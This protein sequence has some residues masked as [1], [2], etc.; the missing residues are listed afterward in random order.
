MVCENASTS[1]SLYVG[2]GGISDSDDND[3]R[4][5]RWGWYKF[6]RHN[7]TFLFTND[8]VNCLLLMLPL[9]LL[10]QWH[11]AR[12]DIFIIIHT[13]LWEN[14]ERTACAK[15]SFRVVF[16]M[17]GGA[18]CGRPL[19][20]AHRFRVC[21]HFWHRLPRTYFYLI[22]IFTARPAAL[23][24]PVQSISTFWY[25]F[26]IHVNINSI[27]AHEW[28]VVF[29]HAVLCTHTHTHAASINLVCKCFCDGYAI[30]MLPDSKIS[31]LNILVHL[32]SF[33]RCQA[34]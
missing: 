5:V 22:P 15:V 9:L 34:S 23:R 20:F 11:K 16:H 27:C 24:D 18:A 17:M 32:S 19:S 2:G 30:C 7:E 33:G 28:W 8:N 6:S 13:I 4:S 3:E 12:A 10:V 29:V 26:H 14:L 25:W 1:S 21:M 31:T